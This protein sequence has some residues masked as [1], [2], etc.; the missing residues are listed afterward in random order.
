MTVTKN[1][2]LKVYDSYYQKVMKNLTKSVEKGSSPEEIAKTI[3]KAAMDNNPR[4]RYL[5]GKLNE[6]VYVR[7][8]LPVRLFRAIVRFVM[9][10]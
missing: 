4:L 7:K 10:R 3:Y 5:T 9:E 6:I 1:D 2:N 8:L